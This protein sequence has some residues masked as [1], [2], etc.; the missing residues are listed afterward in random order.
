MTIEDQIKKA[1]AELRGWHGIKLTELGVLVGHAPSDNGVDW[2]KTIPPVT[3]EVMWEL[4][5]ELSGY[6]AVKYE[7][8]LLQIWF[9]HWNQSR[10]NASWPNT[11][12]PQALWHSTALHRAE[13]MLKLRG[14]WTA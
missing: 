14:K 2:L 4:E 12:W 7:N 9:A 11:C 1:I 8:L 6:D 5:D 13:A 10:A 3:L